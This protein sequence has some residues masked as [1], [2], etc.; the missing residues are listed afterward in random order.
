MWRKLSPRK[1]DA[2]AVKNAKLVIYTELLITILKMRF[3]QLRKKVL[4]ISDVFPYWLVEKALSI[5]TSTTAKG[6]R[7]LIVY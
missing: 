4:E 5:F 6:L 3:D 1:N 7:Y 2:R